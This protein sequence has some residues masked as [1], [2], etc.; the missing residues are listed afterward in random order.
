MTRKRGGGG[1][2]SAVVVG[3]QTGVVAKRSYTATGRQVG[4][5]MGRG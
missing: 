1:G 5:Q 2:K 4:W 3:N